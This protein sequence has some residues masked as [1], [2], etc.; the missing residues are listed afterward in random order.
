MRRDGQIELQ[1]DDA[2]ILSLLV[3]R[4]PLAVQ[5]AYDRWAEALYAIALGITHDEESAG[6]IL[7]DAF[8]QVWRRPELAVA[9]R[10]TLLGYLEGLVLRGAVASSRPAERAALGST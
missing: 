6:R 1:A 7:I 10:R 9:S 8:L 3:A 4:E 5:H 2:T